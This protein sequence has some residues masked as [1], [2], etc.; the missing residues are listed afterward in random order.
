MIAFID[1]YRDR[2]SV[3]FMCATLKKNRERGFITSRGYR[4]TKTR[5]LS[6]RQVRDSEPVEIIRVVHVENYGVYGVHKCGML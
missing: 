5:G 4:D 6:A 3:E 1:E 2:F